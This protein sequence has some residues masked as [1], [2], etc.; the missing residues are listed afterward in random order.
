[1]PSKPELV[2]GVHPNSKVE[3]R[4]SRLL[5]SKLASYRKE[6][7]DHHD[8]DRNDTSDTI[9]L[10]AEGV[11]KLLYG[12]DKATESWH[13]P[14]LL[15]ETRDKL[16]SLIRDEV[17]SGKIVVPEINA[18]N[19]MLRNTLFKYFSTTSTL[20]VPALLEEKE[21]D[22]IEREIT[23][24]IMLKTPG[25]TLPFQAQL[26]KETMV[27]A[28]VKAEHGWREVRDAEPDKIKRQSNEFLRQNGEPEFPLAGLREYPDPGPAFR[29]I[30]FQLSG[31]LAVLPQRKP[32]V[33]ATTM[34]MWSDFLDKAQHV[35]GYFKRA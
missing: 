29:F 1:M 35:E 8:G 10:S 15:P 11:D 21:R 6:F 14:T 5:A 9:F 18:A 34:E 25:S 31:A 16:R 26:I 22:N 32:A 4:R 17:S 23:L 33:W 24:F 7:S 19:R 13:N 2:T 20:P 30:R 27:R 12:A 28:V 3:S